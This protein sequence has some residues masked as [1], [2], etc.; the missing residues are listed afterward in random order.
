MTEQNDD[1]WRTSP[2]S[3]CGCDWDGWHCPHCGAV[4]AHS[5]DAWE[6]KHTLS[7]HRRSA[8]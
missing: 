7:C 5:G 6:P 8:V 3:P 2:I 4:T 1:F